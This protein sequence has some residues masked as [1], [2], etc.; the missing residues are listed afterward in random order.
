MLR[1]KQEACIDI[2]VEMSES[3]DLGVP[4]IKHNDVGVTFIRVGIEIGVI[5]VGFITKRS[6]HPL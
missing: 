3:K 6:I 2:H 1:E 4:S 5:R